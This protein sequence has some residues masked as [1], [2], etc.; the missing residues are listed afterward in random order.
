MEGFRGS[1]IWSVSAHA[2][3]WV[4]WHER[5]SRIYDEKAQTLE[6]FIQQIKEFAFV[7]VIQEP[8]LKDPFGECQF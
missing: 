7:W 5:N 6:K 4:I 2:L 1:L 3:A 8:S